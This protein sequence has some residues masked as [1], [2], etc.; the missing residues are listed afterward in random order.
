MVWLLQQWDRIDK[1]YA[2]GY[3][4]LSRMFVYL[5]FVN[6]D[7]FSIRIAAGKA[8]C[9]DVRDQKNPVGVILN[10]VACVGVG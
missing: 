4:R 8:L 3:N 6:M 7:R 2:A 10:L 9:D 5:L 1:T